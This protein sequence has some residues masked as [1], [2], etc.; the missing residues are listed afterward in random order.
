MS[1]FDFVRY[2]AHL[3]RAAFQNFKPLSATQF[4]AVVSKI[5]FG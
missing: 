2:T 5:K 1:G 3:A 4:Q